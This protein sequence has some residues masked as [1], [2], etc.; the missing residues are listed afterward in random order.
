MS[1][2]IFA[3][4]WLREKLTARD[5][6]GTGLVIAGAVI[7]VSFGSHEETAYS[8]EQLQAL[9]LQPAMAVY[10]VFIIALW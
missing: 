4:F 2:V 3:H 7:S 1:N 8:I 9:Y 5:L 6:I 10:G